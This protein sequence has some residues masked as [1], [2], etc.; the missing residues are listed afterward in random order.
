MRSRSLSRSCAVV[1]FC[2]TALALPAR[3]SGPSVAGVAVAFARVNL[4][5]GTVTAF[6]GRGT[7]SVVTGPSGGSGLI[8]LFSGRYPRNLTSAAV[9]VQATAEASEPDQFAV[10]NAI[11]ANASKDQIVVTVYGWTAGT[12]TPVDGY[13]FITLFLGEPPKT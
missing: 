2:L 12:Q 9:V 6:G 5:D 8:V 3:A 1:A 11:V 7:R 10:A 13:V 4:A